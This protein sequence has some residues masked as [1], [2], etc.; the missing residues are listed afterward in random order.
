M[1]LLTTTMKLFFKRPPEVHKMLGKLLQDATEDVSNQD[2]HDRALLYYRLLRTSPKVAEAVVGGASPIVPLERGFAEEEDFETRAE[3][4]KEFN[5]LSILYGKVSENFIAEEF[6]LKHVLMP[7]E[8]I[9][10]A[11]AYATEEVSNLQGQLEQTSLSSP[12]PVAEPTLTAP[13]PDATPQPTT[14]PAST[15]APAETAPIVADLLDFMDSAPVSTPQP[16]SSPPVSISFTAGFTMTGD[17]YQTMWGAQVEAANTSFSLNHLPSS[18][19]QIEAGL[20]GVNLYTMASGELPTE[21]KLFLYGKED[22]GSTF[23]LQ[24]VIS[25]VSSQTTLVVKTDG[26]SEKADLVVNKIKEIF[27]AL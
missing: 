12:P 11:A 3:L 9:T 7:D 8:H 20:A 26:P 5:T 23:L 16:T 13:V 15:P 10:T 18:T 25:K 21:F 1:A 24:A 2:L 27:A 22:N 4:M 6:Q 19:D 14:I 17:E